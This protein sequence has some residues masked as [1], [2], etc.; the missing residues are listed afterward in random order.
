MVAREVMPFDRSLWGEAFVPTQPP[1][2]PCPSCYFSHGGRLTA[3]LSD[4]H[5]EVPQRLIFSPRFR[6]TMRC[7]VALCG[8]VVAVAGTVGPWETEVDGK[9][10]VHAEAL[11]PSSFF[12]APPIIAASDAQDG[13]TGLLIEKSSE[14]FWV[15][16][17]SCMNCVRRII[18]RTLDNFGVARTHISKKGKEERIP[19]HVRIQHFLDTDEYVAESFG[20]L[21]KIGNMGSHGEEIGRETM[22]DAYELLDNC[23]R[24]LYDLSP[25]DSLKIKMRMS[26]HAR[27]ESLRATLRDLGG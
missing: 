5:V 6:L 21:K 12:P 11:Y 20:A 14:L 2:F 17:E 18:E 19:L 9:R 22:L 7:D 15:E 23:M 3:D 13:T 26:S 16:P 8:E 1:R 24:H 10:I 4:L 25:E 27:I